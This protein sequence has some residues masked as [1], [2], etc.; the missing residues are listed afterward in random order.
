M[1]SE[2]R[3]TFAQFGI[4][5][6]KK[7]TNFRTRRSVCGGVGRQQRIVGGRRA[8]PHEFP[9]LVLLSHAGTPYCGGALVTSHHVLTAA[10]CLYGSFHTNLE[11]HSNPLIK[12]LSFHT[13]PLNPPRRLKRRWP[14]D[15]LR[16]FVAV[17]ISPGPRRSVVTSHRKRVCQ[18]TLE[19]FTPPNADARFV[20]SSSFVAYVHRELEETFAPEDLASSEYHQTER[21]IVWEMFPNVVKVT[22][23]KWLSEVERSVDAFKSPHVSVQAKLADAASGRDWNAIKTDG[24]SMPK[25]NSNP[26]PQLDRMA[27][28]ASDAVPDYSPLLHSSSFLSKI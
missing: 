12:A 4:F 23:E 21:I 14:R 26:L 6:F 24:Y 27:D 9:W 15:M 19:A 7:I 25:M 5:M 18:P 2:R 22:A 10:H 3:N 8:D 17:T 13:R 28:P 16:G 11:F 1:A 20:R